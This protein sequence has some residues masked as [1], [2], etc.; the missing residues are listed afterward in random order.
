MIPVL[1]DLRDNHRMVKRQTRSSRTVAI[2][3]DDEG[4]RL[5]LASLVHS[6]G[7]EVR[8]FGSALDLLA[9]VERMDPDCLIADI[10]MPQ[11]TGDEMQ[12]RLVAAGHRFPM[13]FTTAISTDAIHARVMAAGAACLLAKPVDGSIISEWLARL[14]P[15]GARGV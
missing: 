7:Y 2:V 8:S 3:D 11:M 6:L 12:A 14:V 13:I 15:I 1:V 5:A 9:A 4:V 10:R